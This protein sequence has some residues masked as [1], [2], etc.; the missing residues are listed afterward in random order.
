VAWIAPSHTGILQDLCR[1]RTLA[2]G[3]AGLS[4]GHLQ[5]KVVVK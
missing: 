2:D 5:T 3:D 1:I 4:L